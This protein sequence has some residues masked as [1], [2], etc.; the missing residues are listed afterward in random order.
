MGGFLPTAVLGVMQLGLD[1]AQRSQRIQTSYDAQ[2]Q[3]AQQQIDR[4]ARD[5]ENEEQRRHEALRRSLA[6]QRTRFAAQGVSQGGSANAVLQGLSSDVD[7]ED[8]R[9]RELARAKVDEINT[10]LRLAKRRNLLETTQPNRR[11]AFSL[12][13]QGL[14]QNSLLRF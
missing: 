7:E 6:A 13:Q 4:V 8:R 3:R 10:N 2:D 5:Q 1:A 14:R 12:I 11:G 9:S